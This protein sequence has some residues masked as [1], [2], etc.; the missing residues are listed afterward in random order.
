MLMQVKYL[1]SDVGIP[2]ERMAEIVKQV[3][4]LPL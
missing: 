2:A 4:P 3:L 1:V